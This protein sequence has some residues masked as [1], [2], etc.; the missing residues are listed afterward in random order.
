MG[1]RAMTATERQ[2]RWRA[3]LRASRPVPK[4]AVSTAPAQARIRVLEAEIEKLQVEVTRFMRAW[5][6]SWTVTKACVR[7]L[8]AE[9]ASERARREALVDPDSLPKSYRKRYIARRGLER[10]FA[11]RVKQ[12]AHRVL[13]EIFLPSF[14]R[15]N[16]HGSLDNM[17]ARA[18]PLVPVKT[19]Y[20]RHAIWLLDT[21]SNEVVGPLV[22]MAG[23]ATAQTRQAKRGRR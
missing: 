1:K 6:G 14:E 20:R 15:Q 19:G 13:D 23:R 5:A 10:A 17:L 3:K 21:A 7:E 8:E 4:P 16:S 12:E 11:D 18:K 22:R 9:L 2:R